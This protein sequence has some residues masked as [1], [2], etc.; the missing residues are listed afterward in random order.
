MNFTN[1]G[2]VLTLYFSYFVYAMGLVTAS[3]LATPLAAQ[4][5]VESKDVVGVFA[6]MAIGKFVSYPFAGLISD[7]IG[8]KPTAL[9]GIVLCAVFFAA[10]PLSPSTTVGMVLAATFGVANSMLDAGTYPTLMESNPNNAGTMNIVIKLFI[11]SGQF[12]MPM[13]VTAVGD[14]WKLVPY[15]AAGYMAVMAI[16]TFIWRFPDSKAIAAEQLAER[17]AQAEQLAA[18]GAE[19]NVKARFVFEGVICLI[20]IFCTNGVVYLAN[21]ALPQI[22]GAI[23]G[24]EETVARGLTQYMTLGSVACVILTA[25]LAT[26]GIKSV[27]FVPIYGFMSLISVLLINLGFMQNL[28][29]MRIAAFC[30]GFFV[31]GGVMQLVLTAMSQFFPKNKGQ[32]TAWYWMS[33]SLGGFVLPYAVSALVPSV[34]DVA[35]EAHK[36]SLLA[37]GYTNVVWLAVAFGVAMFVTAVVV[38]VRH[39]QLF[40][41]TPDATAPATTAA[42]V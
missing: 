7:K 14:N 5:G 38:W 12:L 23:A 27:N 31:S 8:R 25:I 29:G 33:G 10:L 1:K 2:A 41:P 24:L 17:E 37:G 28:T 39:R 11:S 40:K 6:V 22:G 34:A 9:I 15:M 3:Q 4:W 20:F 16:L 36:A 19:A 32:I 21:Q 18:S 42:A 30:I 35:D 26:R 13:L